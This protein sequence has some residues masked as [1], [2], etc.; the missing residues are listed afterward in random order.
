MTARKR[1]N[2]RLLGA[3]SYVLHNHCYENLKSHICLCSSQ[4]IDEEFWVRRQRESL[5]FYCRTDL[6][7]ESLQ[8]YCRTDFG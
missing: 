2:S 5:Q 6:Q 7:R 4:S 3:A 1:Q 8:F